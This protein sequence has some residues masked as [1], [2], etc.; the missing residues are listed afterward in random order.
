MEKLTDRLRKCR[1]YLEDKEWSDREAS[2]HIDTVNDAISIL[3]ELELETFACAWC[4]ERI[5]GY[6]KWC[7]MCGHEIPHAKGRE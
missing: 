7:P 2:V 6:W 3:D 5:Y 1:R 4:D